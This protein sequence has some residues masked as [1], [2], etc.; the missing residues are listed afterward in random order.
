[1]EFLINSI[2]PAVAEVTGHGDQFPE[3][4]EQNFL[5]LSLEC[6]EILGLGF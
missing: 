4:A 6:V 2:P 3:S 1:M 5:I